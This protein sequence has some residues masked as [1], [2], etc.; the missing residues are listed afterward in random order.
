MQ[1]LCS[2]HANYLWI[3]TLCVCMCV[4]HLEAL[5]QDTE[6]RSIGQEGWTYWGC[7]SRRS[8]G[9]SGTA[10]RRRC[11]TCRLLFTHA[12]LWIPETSRDTIKILLILNWNILSKTELWQ[13][14][15][16]RASSPCVTVAVR[17]EPHGPVFVG[18]SETVK[19]VRSHHQE[20]V[21]HLKER[22]KVKRKRSQ[23][24]CKL[25]IDW[26]IQKSA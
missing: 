5:Q 22:T 4:Y 9:G 7:W 15:C 23:R 17:A 21:K 16:V 3:Q 10:S 1:T 20:E 8:S 6:G 26:E 24:A 2:M 18:D 13:K 25:Q 14:R 11:W 19:R 12:L